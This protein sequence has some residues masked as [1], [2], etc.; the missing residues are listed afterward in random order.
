MNIHEELISNINKGECVIFCG[1]GIS[2]DSGIPIVNQLVPYILNKFGLS[3][4]EYNRMLNE[5]KSLQIPFE[6][7][8]EIIN[9]N[10]QI[11]KL[12]EIFSKGIPNTNH[13]LLSNL[14]KEGKLKTV[15]TT[16]FD[17]LIEDALEYTI[18]SLKKN[19]DYDVLFKEEEFEKINW[20]DDRIRII[21]LHGSIDHPEMMAITLKRIAMKDLSEARMSITE[22][23][24]STGFHSNVIVLGYSSS[25]AFDI[26]PQIESINNNYKKVFYIQHSENEGIIVDELKNQLDKNPFKNFSGS[27]RIEINT[28]NFIKEIWESVIGIDYELMS[29][30]TK[31]REKIDEWYVSSIKEESQIIKYLIPA[32][33]YSKINEYSLAIKFYNETLK[34]AEGTNNKSLE[35]RIK[36]NLARLYNAKGDVAL[37]MNYSK[38]ALDISDKNKDL[39]FLH[40]SILGNLGSIFMDHGEF[41]KALTYTTKALE[42]SIKEK[43]RDGEA[44]WTGALG[45]NCMYRGFFKKGKNCFEYALKIASEDGNKREELIWIGAIASCYMEMQKYEEG[46][47]QYKIAYNLALLIGDRYNQAVWLDAMGVACYHLN[48][49]AEAI[50]YREE[51]LKIFLII[52]NKR[53]IAKCLYGRACNVAIDIEMRFQH[54]MC[55]LEISKEVNDRRLQ[56]MC[57]SLHASYINNLKYKDQSIYYHKSGIKIA[58]EIGDKKSLGVFLNRLANSYKNWGD[59]K[60]A[61]IKY[62]EALRTFKKFNNKL[63]EIRCIHEIGLTYYFGKKYNK[64]IYYYKKALRLSKRIN[65]LQSQKRILM[66][67]GII[68][69]H[70]KMFS[71]SLRYYNRLASI[72]K[73]AD[74]P[75]GLI[76]LKINIGNLCKK[77]GKLK[78]GIKYFQDAIYFSKIE[79]NIQG[80]AVGNEN[81]GNSFY[82]LERWDDTTNSYLE[83]LKYYEIMLGLNH[84]ICSEIKKKLSIVKSIRESKIT[85][86]LNT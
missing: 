34:I 19:I 79:K 21:K 77:E 76:G 67:M 80:L 28:Q 56:S 69:N 52:N 47:E 1:S 29:S 83:S 45:S 59:F 72:L 78:E 27:K 14:I 64:A 63:E 55:A 44:L 30:S 24:F 16:N 2:K 35:A 86:T 33:I 23:V 50:K 11:N 66:D 17:T 7:F 81:L 58:I 70:L 73:K 68:Y 54:L 65:D 38:I 22:R 6:A 62:N 26:S 84:K 31:W 39:V 8:I 61:K 53:E 10:C 85:V 41:D 75:E 60:N 46:F 48:R 18:P 71:K 37:A 82:L 12:L 13:L 20:E 25:D 42:I 36:Y 3:K 15:I 74:D 9:S 51:S 40:G 4:E 43:D 32:S 49:T 5:D 57:Y